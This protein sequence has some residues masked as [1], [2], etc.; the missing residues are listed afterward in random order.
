M[1]H[2]ALDATWPLT[3]LLARNNQALGKQH[4][5]QADLNLKIGENSKH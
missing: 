1:W 5:M 4:R 3:D 2:S